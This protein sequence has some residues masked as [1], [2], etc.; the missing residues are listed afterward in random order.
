MVSFRNLNGLLILVLF[1]LIICI[2]INLTVNT[3]IKLCDFAENISPL[4]ARN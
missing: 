4:M 2:I 3:K 1:I